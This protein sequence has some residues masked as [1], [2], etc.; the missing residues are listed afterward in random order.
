MRSLTTLPLFGAPC[1]SPHRRRQIERSM[2]HELFCMLRLPVPS[3]VVVGQIRLGPIHSRVDPA[4]LGRAPSRMQEPLIPPAAPRDGYLPRPVS[5]PQ[6][7]GL[8][9]PRATHPHLVPP[10]F[11]TA[12]AGDLFCQRC[13]EESSGSYCA[14]SARARPLRDCRERLKCARSSSWRTSAKRRE[15]NADANVQ[16]EQKG[17]YSNSAAGKD[18]QKRCDV[19]FD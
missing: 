4:S 16:G 3:S 6:Q 13:E 12:P 9:R 7:S 8:T 17:G 11:L 19:I 14:Q 1:S 10:V 5:S 15:A 18:G 2:W